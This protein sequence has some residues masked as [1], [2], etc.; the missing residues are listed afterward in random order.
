MSKDKY[1]NIFSP[2][3]EAVVFIILQIFFVTRAVL[4]IGRYSR[5][6]PSFSWVIFGHVMCLDQS[7]ASEKIWIISCHIIQ[8]ERNL[9]SGQKKGN[10]HSDF[11]SSPA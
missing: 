4:K 11:L 7:R 1:P 10:F 9:L 5:I 8:R 6:S 3:M 2:Q